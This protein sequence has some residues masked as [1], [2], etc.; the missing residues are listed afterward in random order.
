[1]TQTVPLAKLK[2][3]EKNVRTTPPRNIEAMASSIRARGIMQNL[4]VTAARP[5]GTYE[6]IA[7]DRRYLGAM[8]LADAGEIDAAT[9]DVP[10]KIVSG[11]DADLREVSLT[12]N[13]QREP[14]TAA[15]ECVAF[16]HF[17]KSDGDIDAVANRFGQ[18]RRFIEGRLRLANLAEPIFEALSEGRITLEMAKAYGSTEDKAK[19]ERVFQQY[20]H[21]SYVN[22][23]QIR[24]AIA[25]DTMKASDP[26][27]MLVGADAYVAAGGKVECD[28]FSEDGDRWSDPEL[29]QTLAAAIME[30]EA[31]RVGEEQGL[32]WVRPI[33]N[34]SLYGATADLHRVTLEPA[35]L[36]DEEAA[37]SDAI[38]ERCEA[39]EEQM[40]D[41]DL[42]EAVYAA[43]EEEFERLREEYQALHSKPPVLA[44]EMK[45]KVGT[46]LTLG[47][48]GKMTLESTYFSETPLKGATGDGA[49]SSSRSARDTSSLP[50]EAVAPGG[51]PLSARLHDEL[52]VQ[53]R[54]ILAASI[55]ADPA[56]A[57]DYMLFAMADQGRSYRRYGTTITA[58]RPQDPQMPKDQPATQAQLAI[59]E[60]RE[61]LVSD[62]TTAASP[63]ERFEAFRALDDDAKA[64]WLAVTV[65]SSLEAK[66]DYSSAKTNPL[67]GR[68]AS[69]L[70]I[71]VAKWWRPTSANF[72]DR[73]SKG[74]L[75]ALLTEVGGPVLA[76]R[77]V[78]SKKGEIS[79]SCEKLFAGEAITEAETK[80]AA[81]AWVPDAMRFD[82]VS[83]LGDAD[84]DETLDDEDASD[85]EGGLTSDDPLEELADHGHDDHEDA[86]E[87]VNDDATLIAAE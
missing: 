25:N 77:Y 63:V 41:E 60:A 52:A 78:G 56:L 59:G 29:A 57:L 15:E 19:Q 32:A 35:P 79:T 21:S 71:D 37:R 75:L 42:E 68:L 69:I 85:A 12:E 40:A 54:D 48:D 7:G 53:R 84:I 82:A 11:N 67:H 81:L 51:K 22:A 50:P 20:G 70:E 5:K 26:V 47:R 31:K 39:L 24:R 61:A 27:A 49:T 16:Q 86:L 3:S 80:E 34:T 8:M 58:G 46:F 44:D 13:F 36:D 14:M 66:P 18:T 64:S 10:V 65:A 4:L 2:R 73:V 62:W 23:D 87:P 43:L 55:L 1:M 30:A 83:S 28:L 17:L 38:V 74:T 72:F 45:G 9:Y 33:A 76:A 6:I